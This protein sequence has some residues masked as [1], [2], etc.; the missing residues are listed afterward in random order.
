MELADA[1]SFL[2]GSQVFRYETSE[3]LA[4]ELAY[5]RRFGLGFDWPAR[6]PSLVEAVTKEDLLRVAVRLLDPDRMVTVVSGYTGAK[7]AAPT[8]PK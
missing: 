7:A 4:G 2:V 5:L 8:P 6:F 3:Q 1:K